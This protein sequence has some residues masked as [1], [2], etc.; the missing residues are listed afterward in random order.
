MKDHNLP[1]ELPHHVFVLTRM[2]KI[3]GPIRY[4]LM[5]HGG[6]ATERRHT[7]LKTKTLNKIIVRHLT[8]S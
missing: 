4:Y 8:K 7:K 1:Y 3:Y 5:L 6:H 2:K